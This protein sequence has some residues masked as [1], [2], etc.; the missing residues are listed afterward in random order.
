MIREVIK[1][2]KI[3]MPL[4]DE[5][6]LR[7]AYD[8]AKKAHEGQYRKSGCPY[9]VHPVAAAMILTAIPMLQL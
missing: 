4:L 8:F 9:I 1:A 5:K 6:R 7:E 2:A 3:Y